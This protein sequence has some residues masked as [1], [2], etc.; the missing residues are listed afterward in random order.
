M[1][2]PTDAQQFKRAGKALR[3][4]NT[5]LGQVNRDIV[6][7]A[8]DDPELEAAKANELTLARRA[9]TGNR[10]LNRIKGLPSDADLRVFSLHVPEVECTGPFDKFRR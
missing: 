10:N 7:K 3:T 1:T 4:L 9:H 2:S 5:Y 6:R 8:K